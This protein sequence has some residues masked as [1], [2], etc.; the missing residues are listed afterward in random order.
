MK[1]LVACEESGRVCAA[2]REKGHEAFSCDIKPTSGKLPQ[3][4]I[5]DNVL[6][7]LNKG[8]DMLIAFPPCT[9]L[10]NSQ[11]VRLYNNPERQEKAQ[12]AKEFFLTLYNAKIE[13]ICIE[14]P[15]PNKSIG[16]PEYTQIINPFEYGSKYKKRTCLWLKNL[17][18]LIAHCQG[19][20][21]DYESWTMKTRNAAIRSKTFEEIAKA[22]AQ[23]WN[24]Q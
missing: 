18:P 21:K 20:A 1:I 5:I 6:N 9:Y 24:F 23:Q 13:R 12:Q 15:V 16:L 22:M 17:P 7:Q 3:Y 4:H 2:F 14:N 11:S 19:K 10:T 8:W